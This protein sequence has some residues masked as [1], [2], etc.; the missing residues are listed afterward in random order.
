MTFLNIRCRNL[1]DLKGA[2]CYPV[3]VIKLNSL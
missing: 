1:Q 2:S 3:G